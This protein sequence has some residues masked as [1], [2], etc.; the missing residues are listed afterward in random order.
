MNEQM[1]FR[2][3]FTLADGSED[4]V[5]VEGGS[6]EEVQQAAGQEVAKRNGTDPWSEPA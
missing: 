6:I 2:I 5:V 3:H 1:R 4:S